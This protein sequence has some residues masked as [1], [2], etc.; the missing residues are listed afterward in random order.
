MLFALVNFIVILIIF[1]ITITYFVLQ[2]Y[3][4]DQFN[5]TKLI[6]VKF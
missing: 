3:I 2:H 1:V 4:N 5:A 6:F